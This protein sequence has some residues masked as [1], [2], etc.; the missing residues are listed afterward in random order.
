MPISKTLRREAQ[1]YKNDMP[2]VKTVIR[3]K[4]CKKCG[5]LPL[6]GREMY[7]SHRKPI[8]KEESICEIRKR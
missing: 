4:I 8:R 3:H 6:K 1:A 5:I 2:P 7:N